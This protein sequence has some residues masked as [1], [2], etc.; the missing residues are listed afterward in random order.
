MQDT[1]QT[2]NMGQTSATSSERTARIGA[3]KLRLSFTLRETERLTG[4]SY[5]TIRN[6]SR[7]GF[8]SSNPN[9]WELIALAILS[10]TN[11]GAGTGANYGDVLIKRTM[12]A[13]QG[14]D[15][16]LLLSEE[17]QGPYLA[18]TAAA[19]SNAALPSGELQMTEQD[20][21]RLARV[22]SAIDRKA[23]MA[24]SNRRR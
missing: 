13:V 11:R 1:A 18:E 16:A 12:S 3:P 20:M 22:V 14:L 5:W 9:A 15:D 17:Q 19:I 23:T 10:M 6:W 8:I 24:R 7:R 2:A 4:L 21:E